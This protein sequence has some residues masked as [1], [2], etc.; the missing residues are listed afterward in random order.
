MPPQVQDLERLRQRVHNYKHD[1]FETDDSYAVDIMEDMLATLEAVKG[2]ALVGPVTCQHCGHQTPSDVMRSVVVDRPDCPVAA[3]CVLEGCMYGVLEPLRP[4]E[5]N[6]LP[7]A[8]SYRI[9]AALFRDV[10]DCHSLLSNRGKVL[11]DRLPERVSLL[12]DRA[13][14]GEQDRRAMDAIRAALK[15]VETP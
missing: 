14:A 7:L 8:E 1:E 2:N 15:G 10:Q 12:C 4:S 5:H 13:D 6:H 9:L 11:G 3:P